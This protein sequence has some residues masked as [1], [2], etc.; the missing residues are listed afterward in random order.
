[1]PQLP[2]ILRATD[3]AQ[4]ANLFSEFPVRQVIQVPEVDAIEATWATQ[5]I[6]D[7]FSGTLMW[8]IVRLPSASKDKR[9]HLAIIVSPSYTLSRLSSCFFLALYC[10][11][12]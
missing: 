12:G 3:A 9:L 8:T 6:P 4:M 1:M 10:S 7:R 11:H 2:L 5:Y